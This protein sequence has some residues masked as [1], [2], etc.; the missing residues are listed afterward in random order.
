MK[1]I[2]VFTFIAALAL[3]AAQLSPA[4]ATKDAKEANKLARDG[5]RIKSGTKRSTRFAKRRLSTTNT[6]QTS[7][8]FTNNVDTL[9]RV[10]SNFRMP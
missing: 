10:T 2:C 4:Q 3:C 7:R 1:K 8:L 6:R 5:A 9:R